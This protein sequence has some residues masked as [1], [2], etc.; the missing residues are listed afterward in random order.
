M[1]HLPFA[2]G[3]LPVFHVGHAVGPNTAHHPNQDE[4]SNC[5]GRVLQSFLDESD[6]C[7]PFFFLRESRVR[8]SLLLST[9]FS[10]YAAFPFSIV[11]VFS[12]FFGT[13]TARVLTVNRKSI[14]VLH[15]SL[16]GTKCTVQPRPEI[17]RNRT[18][19]LT[20]NRMCQT[21][22]IIDHLHD[23]DRLP[24]R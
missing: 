16:R 22:T 23:R 14:Q 3:V 11:V 15:V 24:R 7:T 5:I 10:I 6:S 12:L 21:Y 8:P 17:S 2:P 13:P 9:F 18:A 1:T 4:S 19:N 20:L